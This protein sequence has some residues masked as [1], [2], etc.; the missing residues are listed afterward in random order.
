[1]TFFM[2]LSEFFHAVFALLPVEPPFWWGD[3]MREIPFD[4][5]SCS[6]A[7]IKEKGITK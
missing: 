3:V 1:M 2:Y 7:D 4:V 5:I 6:K